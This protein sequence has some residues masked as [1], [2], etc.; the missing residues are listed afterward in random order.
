[1]I[2][3]PLTRMTSTQRLMIHRQVLQC[4]WDGLTIKQIAARLHLRVDTT[5]RIVRRMM[6]D[7]QVD[8]H[9]GLV[10]R[11]LEEGLIRP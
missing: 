4:L 1:M 8:S 11:A 10:R 3:L 9:V 2:V 7:R 5:G 6:L